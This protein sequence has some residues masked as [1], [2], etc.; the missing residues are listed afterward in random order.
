MT[1]AISRSAAIDIIDEERRFIE[2]LRETAF[3]NEDRAH[4]TGELGCAIRLARKIKVLPALDVAQIVTNG[5]DTTYLRVKS[6]D[7]LR[8]RIVIDEESGNRCAMYY[9][10]AEDFAPV[11]HAMWIRDDLGNTRCSNC[12]TRLPFRHCYDD[13]DGYEWDDEIDETP[14]CM[15]CGARMDGE[16]E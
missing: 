10:E 15:H 5:Q 13:E 16:A 11:V 6:L 3:D 1:D 9:E 7:G 4:N 12:H 8:G 14:W 2:S